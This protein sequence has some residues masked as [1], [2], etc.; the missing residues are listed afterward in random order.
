[1]KRRI[2]SFWVAIYLLFRRAVSDTGFVSSEKSVRRLSAGAT[3]GRPASSVSE[4][5]GYI[6]SI[7][8]SLPIFPRHS[9]DS[10][11]WL[12]L[13]HEHWLK[14]STAAPLPGETVAFHLGIKTTRRI[15]NR[16]ERS[17]VDSKQLAFCLHILQSITGVAH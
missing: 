5:E 15:Q 3:S 10:T 2:Q 12:T 8:N 9:Q 16:D 11:L 6:R 4:I 13:K 14:A 17:H 7:A 1:M